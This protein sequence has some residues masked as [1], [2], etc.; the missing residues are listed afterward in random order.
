VVLNEVYPTP[1]A[2]TTEPLEREWVELFNDSA[3]V[4]DIANWSLGEENSSAVE[5]RHTI[6]S[7][8]TCADG[9]KV[10]FARP[11]NGAS[12]SIAPGGRVVIEFCAQTR[13]RNSGDVVRL[14]NVTGEL[15]DQHAFGVTT[16]GKSHARIPDGGTWVD[17]LPTPGTVNTVTVADLVAEGWTPPE[18]AAVQA[19]VVDFAADTTS[20]SGGTE[21]ET[22]VPSKDPA[23]P[24]ADSVLVTETGDTAPDTDDA[25]APQDEDIPELGATEEMLEVESLDEAEIAS[26]DES[27]IDFTAESPEGVSDSVETESVGGEAPESEDTV[28]PASDTDTPV[29]SDSAMS[30]LMEPQPAIVPEDVVE[31]EAETEETT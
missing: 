13:L 30:E 12:T 21:D 1:L 6:N 10:G 31:P 22:A 16:A 14:Y 27:V 19:V 25:T 5:T 20:S 23:T 26:G 3:D 11:W 28:T 29:D 18:I 4:V 17:P 24:D 8:N 7:T 9:A 15:Q 2:T